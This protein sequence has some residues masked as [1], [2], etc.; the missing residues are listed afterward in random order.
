VKIVGLRRDAVKMVRRLLV[1][2]HAAFKP[3]GDL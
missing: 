3:L 2:R 1:N